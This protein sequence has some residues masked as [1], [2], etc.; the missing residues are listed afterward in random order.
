[1]SARS[2]FRTTWRW[3]TVLA[4]TTIFGLLSALLGQ[5]GVWWWLSWI[6]MVLPLA[7]IVGCVYRG[8]SQAL[9]IV[10]RP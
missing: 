6:T 8:R 3:P 9:P 10:T 4:V 5:G 1:M 7:V 2:S